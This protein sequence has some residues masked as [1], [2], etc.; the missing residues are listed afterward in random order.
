MEFKSA[1]DENNTGREVAVGRRR[2]HVTPANTQQLS[3][4]AAINSE[5]S[6]NM[7]AQA[8]TRHLSEKPTTKKTSELPEVVSGD[9]TRRGNGGLALLAARAP[10]TVASPNLQH[11]SFPVCQPLQQ[12]IAFRT[13]AIEGGVRGATLLH[14]LAVRQVRGEGSTEWVED[15]RRPTAKKRHAL[16]GQ[17]PGHRYKVRV[18]P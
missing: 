9:E 15:Q 16:C 10:R 4:G 6:L 11:L 14:G 5:P 13:F 2:G 1:T 7:S 18:V 17:H 3:D 12:N 8:F